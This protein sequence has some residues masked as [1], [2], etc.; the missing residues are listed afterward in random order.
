M[1]SDL[2]RL[3]LPRPLSDYDFVE[4]TPERAEWEPETTG[5]PWAVVWLDIERVIAHTIAGGQTWPGPV[6]S[7]EEGKLAFFNHAWSPRPRGIFE[8]SL[9]HMP[10]ISCDLQPV[11]TP[12]RW[13]W[14]WRSNPTTDAQKRFIVNF[15]N[16]R[17]RVEYFRHQGVTE[18]P[19]ETRASLTPLLRELCATNGANS[20]PVDLSMVAR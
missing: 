10:R 18:M 9:A 12:P 1:P 14:L 2:Y 6:S 13:R 17:H 15:G 3:N 8:S 7:W 4:L 11:V 16:G 20:S 5:D 19:F